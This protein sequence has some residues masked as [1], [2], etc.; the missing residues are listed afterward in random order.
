MKPSEKARD[1]L[2]KINNGKISKSDWDKATDYAKQDLKRKALIVIDE[3]ESA[4][5]DYG[6]SSFEL[7]NMETEF[8]Y[9]EWVQLAIKQF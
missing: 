3:I 2:E 4:L 7:Q 1:I 9:W 8:R 6:K 5:L